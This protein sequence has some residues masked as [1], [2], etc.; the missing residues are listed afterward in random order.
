[1]CLKSLLAVQQCSEAAA[2]AP[3]KRGTPSD[4]LHAGADGTSAEARGWGGMSGSP[5]LRAHGT[6]LSWG[7]DIGVLIDCCKSF[8]AFALLRSLTSPYHFSSPAIASESVG[9]R[10]DKGMCVA[11][12]SADGHSIPCRHSFK[13][14]TGQWFGFIFWL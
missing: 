13:A 4:A 5:P 12:A 6:H 11:P 10:T 7:D 8:R 2:G 3:S 9:R 1:M 14:N